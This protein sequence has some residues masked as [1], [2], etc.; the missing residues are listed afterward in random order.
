M[1]TT[2]AAKVYIYLKEKKNGEGIRTAI[3]QCKLSIEE[4]WSGFASLHRGTWLWC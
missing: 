1:T 4:G 3:D 2:A